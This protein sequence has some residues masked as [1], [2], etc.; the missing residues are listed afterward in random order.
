MLIK[1]FDLKTSKAWAIKESC[2]A[3]CTYH[4]TYGARKLITHLFGRV[5]RCHFAPVTEATKTTQR[6]F[7]NLLTYCRHEITPAVSEGLNS[8]VQSMKSA[9]CTSL[10]AIHKL[11]VLNPALL[12][13]T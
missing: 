2:R 13:K 12:R 8:G 7:E 3:L 1:R 10:S 11:P 4:Y 9:S 6:H 5:A